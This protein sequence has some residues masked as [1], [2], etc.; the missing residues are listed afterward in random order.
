MH[1]RAQSE[2]SRT[3]SF[4]EAIG[5]AMAVALEVFPTSYVIGLGATDPAGIFGTTR[6]LAET[7][8]KDRVLD[9]PISEN[10]VTG[11]VL[12]SA[13]DGMRPILTHQRLDFALVSIEQLVNQAA[14]WHYM[15]GG[16]M[17]A[18]IVV[19]LVVGRG[20][21]QGPQHSQSLQSWFAHI[22]G[23]KV[24][25]PALPADAKGLLLAAVADP[26]PVIII[27]HRWLYNIVGTVPEG[28]YRQPIGSPRRLREGRD[29]TI[30]STS[31]MTVEA[32]RA[33]EILAGCGIEAEIMDVQTLNPLDDRPIIES[34]RK[35]GRLIAADTGWTS[36]GF[37][38]E[39]IA[40]VAEKAFTALKNPPCRIALPDTPTPTSHKLTEAY[41]PT[42]ADIIRQAASMLGHNLPDGVLEIAQ[43]H[44]LD[45]PD[46]RFR[47]PF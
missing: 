9:M 25:M 1:H 35:T 42:S 15:F 5:E 18:P 43:D 29:L 21:G 10:A 6:G 32:L 40:R 3:I 38:G 37:A 27:E 19:R 45:V 30:A 33:A 47:G 11:V 39:I 22:P 31:Y 36:C 13:I 23:L 8:G 7:F 41:Y 44:P 12:G 26:N 24:V 46:G 28:D 34:V 20:W 14:K 16:I 2:P 17:S 4:T